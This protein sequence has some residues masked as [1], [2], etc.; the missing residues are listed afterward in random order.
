[1]GR[2][3]T[4]ATVALMLTV[5]FSQAQTPALTIVP[6]APAAV[7]ATTSAQTVAPATSSTAS[8]LKLLREMKA[9]NEA[10]LAKQAATL[11]QLQELEKAAEQI[12]IYTKRS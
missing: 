11:L 4:A 6:A 7:Q 8:T 12:K 10:I 2:K 5:A 3:I 1:M 9:A